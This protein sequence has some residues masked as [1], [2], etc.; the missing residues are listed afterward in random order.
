MSLLEANAKFPLKGKFVNLRLLSPDD[1]QITLSWRT[2]SHARLLNAGAV[3]LDQ[4]RIWIASRPPTENNFIIELKSG[5][6][7]GMLSLI[8]INQINRHAETA[9]FLIGNEAAV[10]GV[11]AAVEA[12][13]LIYEYAFHTLGLVRIYG[14][15]AA[16]NTLM[17]KWQKYLGMKEEGRM[18]K[19]FFIDGEWQDGVILGLLIEEAQAESFPKM[20]ALIAASNRDNI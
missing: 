7:V 6:P 5:L 2:S 4:Q 15:V 10:K 8:A 12:M 1:A 13:K 11:P 19:H 9:R 3:D 16:K 17:I 18:R 14:L 20:R